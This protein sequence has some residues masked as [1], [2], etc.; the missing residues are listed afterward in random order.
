MTPRSGLILQVYKLDVAR[1][2]AI[3]AALGRLS[4]DNGRGV[5]APVL[6][7]IIQQLHLNPGLAGNLVSM[8]CLTIALFSPR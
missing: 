7:D 2:E 5:V 4:H 6:P 1:F 8:H 3:S